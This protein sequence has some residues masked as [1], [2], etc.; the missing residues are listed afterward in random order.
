MRP[1]VLFYGDPGVGKTTCCRAVPDALYID[2]E[3]RSRVSDAFVFLKYDKR[4]LHEA[5]K[6]TDRKRVVI[7]S[8]DAL[9]RHIEVYAKA[10]AGTQ[11]YGERWIMRAEE[12]HD[13]MYMLRSL[14]KTVI[15]TANILREDST[16]I[17]EDGTTYKRIL[18]S[19]ALSG[20][21]TG[22]LTVLEKHCDVIGVI[23]RPKETKNTRVDG[24]QCVIEKKTGKRVLT[25]TEESGLLL[26][27]DV[28][29]G[30]I[31]VEITPEGFVKLI[32]T[33]EQ[34]LEA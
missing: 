24:Q 26:T 25:T 6:N 28:I 9:A 27:K 32:E 3:G 16:E 13:L 1:M 2:T 18:Y 22:P 8:V 33:M 11:V 4:K 20:G 31:D 5:L 7:D 19:P 10:A 30:G 23:H 29:T 17:R 15:M 14:D 12:M 21:K 34:Q